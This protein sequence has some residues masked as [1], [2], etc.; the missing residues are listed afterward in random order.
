M[1][2]KNSAAGGMTVAQILKNSGYHTGLIGEWNLG[3]ENSSGAPWEKGFDEFA[4]YLN[5]DEGK[6][7]TPIMF[8]LSAALHFQHRSNRW[9]PWRPGDGPNNGGKEMIYQ[10]I[11]GQKN[12]YLPD[13]HT[14]P[15]EN[16]IK[17]NQ[18]DQFNHYRP[19]FLLLNL[20]APRTLAGPG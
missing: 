8:A 16:F 7:F 12:R 14:R 15:D 1:I 2:G 13:F 9:T 4:G 10:N 6:I 18:P 20:S 5:P 11:G 19:F 3:D 17:N